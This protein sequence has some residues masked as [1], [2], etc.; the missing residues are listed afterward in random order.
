MERNEYIIGSVIYDNIDDCLHDVY[1]CDSHE[2][3]YMHVFMVHV[4]EPNY[5]LDY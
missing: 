3:G 2:R 1:L 5:R 4:I